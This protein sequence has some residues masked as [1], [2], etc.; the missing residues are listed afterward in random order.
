[1]DS[2]GTIISLR[3]EFTP[4]VAEIGAKMEEKLIQLNTAT[5]EE[6]F[7]FYNRRLET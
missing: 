4:K 6:P 5:L 3:N 2:D 1:M 7:N